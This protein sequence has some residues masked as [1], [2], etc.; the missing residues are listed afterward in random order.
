MLFVLKLIAFPFQVVDQ[1]HIAFTEAGMWYPKQGPIYF[2]SVD[3]E[4]LEGGG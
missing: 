4:F 1:F 3:L 2:K